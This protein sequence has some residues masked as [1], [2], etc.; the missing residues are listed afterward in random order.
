MVEVGRKILFG[1]APILPALFEPRPDIVA[2]GR[3]IGLAAFS[4]NDAADLEPVLLEALNDPRPALVN[5]QIDRTAWPPMGAR[6]RTLL[7]AY[8]GAANGTANAGAANGAAK[9]GGR[10]C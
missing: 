10:P 6:M 7:E 1:R 2:I 8:S 3:A 5:V 9:N 4:V